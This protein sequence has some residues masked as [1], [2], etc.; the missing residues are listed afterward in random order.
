MDKLRN[1]T[2]VPMEVNEIETQKDK[3]M[4]ENHRNYPPSPLHWNW[5]L[6]IFNLQILNQYGRNNASSH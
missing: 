1:A 3:K 5:G 6:W 2:I 4:A